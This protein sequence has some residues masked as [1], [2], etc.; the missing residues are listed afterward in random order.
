MR[1]GP[2]A[3]IVQLKTYIIGIRES[4]LDSSTQGQHED[5]KESEKKNPTVAGW[6]RS[7]HSER[8][9]PHQSKLNELPSAM[10]VS[11]SRGSLFKGTMLKHTT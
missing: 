11:D 6:R 5:L 2:F 9:W 4:L 10:D 8:D 7:K 1:G 3:A